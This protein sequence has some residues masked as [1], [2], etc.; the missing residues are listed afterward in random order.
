MSKLVVLSPI[1]FD[2]SCAIRLRTDIL[3]SCSNY[4]VQF[5]FV[6]DSAG[7]DPN[8]EKLNQF[9]DVSIIKPIVNLGH[10]RA[11]VF[12]LRKIINLIEGNP[13]IVTMDSDGED[14]PEDIPRLIDELKG[15]YSFSLAKRTKRQES[16]LFKVMYFFFKLFFSFS[17]GITV[18]T[19]NFACFK[20]RSIKKIIHHPFFDLCYSSVFLSLKLNLNLIPCAR[21]SRYE[22]ESK[23]NTVGLISHGIRML[24]PFLDRISIRVL[25]LFVFIAAISFCLTIASFFQYSIGPIVL[26]RSVKVILLVSFT[27]SSLGCLNMMVLFS[28]FNQSMRD[29][30]QFVDLKILPKKS[31][32][33][34]P[35]E[36]LI[37]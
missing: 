7:A 25:V 37:S 28:L 19:G 30:Y 35:Q 34:E 27:L 36:K 5:Y 11:I 2:V 31:E 16:P 17:T 22:G 24:M 13:V 32:Q 10:Q 9:S 4:D 23:M 8:I 20:L 18:K 29:A 1:Y 12:G 33:E 3:K 26:N 15:E 21:G 6:D 14:V